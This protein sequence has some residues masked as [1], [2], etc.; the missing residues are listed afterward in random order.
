[1]NKLDIVDK[2]YDHV[3]V[4]YNNLPLYSSNTFRKHRK[5]LIWSR[6]N[7]THGRFTTKDF[8]NQWYISPLHHWEY[9]RLLLPWANRLTSE[10]DYLIDLQWKETFN[11][12]INKLCLK[13]PVIQR[14]CYNFTRELRQSCI[15]PWQFIRDNS[16]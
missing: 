5:L 7:I 11:K 8:F 9:W 14:K 10:G 13:N 16:G 3:E 6:N 12:L 15:Q 4:W 2:L 1:M